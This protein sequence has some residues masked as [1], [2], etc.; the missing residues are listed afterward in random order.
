MPPYIEPNDELTIHS[1]AVLSQINKHANSIFDEK[2]I[3]KTSEI[4]AKEWIIDEVPC[5][6]IRVDEIVNKSKQLIKYCDINAL[7]KIPGLSNFDLR[8]WKDISDS[9][10]TSCLD[11]ILSFLPGEMP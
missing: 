4:M 9:L 3:R 6:R 5:R 11:H 10:S 1:F 8:D 7:S 2:S